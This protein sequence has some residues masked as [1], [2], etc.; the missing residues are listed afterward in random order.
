ME[1]GAVPLLDV[2]P[3]EDRVV[4]PGAADDIE[5]FLALLLSKGVPPLPLSVAT[6]STASPSRRVEF[7]HARL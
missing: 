1:A 5:V 2:P 7:S 6:A 3:K 4:R